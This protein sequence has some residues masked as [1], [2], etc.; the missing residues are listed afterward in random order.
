M[1]E[2]TGGENT[3]SDN[4]KGGNLTVPMAIIAAGALVAGAIFITQSSTSV[5]K[6]VAKVPAEENSSITV[7]PVDDT[8]HIRGNPNAEIVIIEY[9]D[10]ECPWCREFH[11]SMKELMETDGKSGRIAWVYRH[12][13]V[14]QQSAREIE[15]LE[16]ATELGGNE[17]FWNYL[18][19][20]FEITPAND[21]FDLA[22]LPEIADY[23]GLDTAAFDA[24]LQSGRYAGVP[25]A[26]KKEAIEAG[27][28]GT[29]YNIV[30]SSSGRHIIPGY[31]PYNNLKAQLEEF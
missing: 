20:L 22:K 31:L 18:D 24:C 11:K 2:Q 6:N 10:T 30:I 12:F 21:Q 13:P 7:R 16:C 19:R 27:A 8:D 15:A 1:T 25:A 26:D 23:A 17:G 29:P 9:S 4:S 14:H 5:D 28:E 3:T